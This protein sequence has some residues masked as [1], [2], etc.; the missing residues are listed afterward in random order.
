MPCAPLFWT[1]MIL[2]IQKDEEMVSV[3]N[4]AKVTGI[5]PSFSFFKR[6]ECN[7]RKSFNPALHVK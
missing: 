4:G 1:L 7:N 5:L 3:I 6:Y 2:L